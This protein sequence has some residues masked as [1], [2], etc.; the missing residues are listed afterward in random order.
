MGTAESL[1]N[2]AQH[3]KRTYDGA[4]GA[5]RQ[6]KRRARNVCDP[7]GQHNERARRSSDPWTAGAGGEDFRRGRRAPHTGGV[8]GA[9]ARL[10]V[11]RRVASDT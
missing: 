4:A 11:A 2:D 10:G 6:A 9:S 5:V 8:S 1:E 7:R 3:S